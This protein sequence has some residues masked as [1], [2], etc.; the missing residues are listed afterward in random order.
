MTP[1]SERETRKKKIDPQLRKAGW[2]I[3]PFREN[4]PLSSYHAVAIEEY[5]TDNGPADYAIDR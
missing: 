4:T 2:D 5:Q 3:Q 1:A